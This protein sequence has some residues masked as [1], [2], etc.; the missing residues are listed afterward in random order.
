MNIVRSAA[1]VMAAGGLLLA[2]C[3]PDGRTGARPAVSATPLTNGIPLL[4]AVQIVQRTSTV[5]KA[6]TSYRV[7]G[8]VTDDGFTVAFDMTIAGE[9]KAGSLTVEGGTA[10]MVRINGVQYVRVDRAF[11]DS[12]LGS[13][14]G[15]LMTDRMDGHWM[16]LDASVETGLARLFDLADVENMLDDIATSNGLIKGV[17]T[18]F[19]RAPVQVLVDQDSGRS[20]SVAT[21]GAPYPLRMGDTTGSNIVFSEFGAEVPKIKAP[22]PSEVVAAPGS[23]TTT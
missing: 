8:N 20:L 16:R 1:V 13:T 11:W 12:V 9:D 3:T 4:D 17:Q 15:K 5:L 21:T 6:A 18:E 19:Q 2:G 10:E 22:D 7:A 14:A 23:T